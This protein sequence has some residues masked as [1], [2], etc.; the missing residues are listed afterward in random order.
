MAEEKSILNPEGLFNPFLKFAWTNITEELFESRWDNSPIRVPAGATVELPHHLAVKFTKELVDKIMIGNAK[1]DELTKNQ[2]FYRSPIGSSL[3]VPAARKVWED[4]I[5]RPI[6]VDEESP[7]MQVTRATIKAELLSDLKKEPGQQ[8][9]QAPIA[10]A[11]P[12]VQEFADLTANT[13][14]TLTTKPETKVKQ[15]SDPTAQKW[16]T[17]LAE[18]RK[19]GKSFAEA[20]E[21]WRARK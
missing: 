15:V 2:P 4:Q 10:F 8:G 17:F 9:V 3:G 16:T 14:T 13:K 19:A 7:Q 6:E 21:L 5:C 11:P 18:Q 20:G 1:L 12:V